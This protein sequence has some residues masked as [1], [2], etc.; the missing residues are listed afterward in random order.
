MKKFYALLLSTLIPFIGIDAQ[1]PIKVTADSIPFGKSKY[2]GIIVTIPEANMET[3]HKDWVKSLQSGTR[4]KVVTENEEMTILG[5]NIKEISKSPVNVYSKIINQDSLVQLSAIIEFKKDVYAESGSGE[6]EFNA[7]KNYLKEFAKDEYVAFA[8]DQLQVEEK[9][10]KDLE[11]EFSSL[12]NDKSKEEKSIE[13]NKERIQ[14][15][16]DNISAQNA[17]LAKLE[18]ELIN[19]NS[20]LDAMEEGVARDEKQKFIKNLEKQKNKLTKDIESSEKKI[21][22]AESEIEESYAAIPRIETSQDDIR[23]RIANQEAIRNRFAE[24]LDTIKAY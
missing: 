16:K 6:L 24:K 20:Q 22:K 14:S 10:L 13:N 7:A 3:V 23:N 12:K 19:Q 17:E 11:N 4:S 21:K 2:P 1:K 8:K 5:A 9:K 15:E 18:A